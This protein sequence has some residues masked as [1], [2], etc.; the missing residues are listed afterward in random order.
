[1]L[2]DKV[3]P[4]IGLPSVE[5]RYIGYINISSSNFIS[6]INI[7]KMPKEYSESVNRRRT[8]NT[9]AEVKRTNNDLKNI[10]IK[11]KIE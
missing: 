9:M 11:L 5:I 6:K 8:D 7:K 2:Y 4:D 10:H 1:L 3:L